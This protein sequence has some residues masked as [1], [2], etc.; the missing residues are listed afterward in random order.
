MKDTILSGKR[1]LYVIGYP[2]SGNTWLARLMAD[3]LDSPLVGGNNPIDRADTKQNYEGQFIIYKLHHSGKSKP[4]NITKESLILYI[5]RDFRD[6]LVSG[7]FHF[8]RNISDD[9]VIAENSLESKLHILYRFYFR[10]QILRMIRQWQGNEIDVL[11]RRARTLYNEFRFV[12]FRKKRT[13]QL[14]IGNWSEH[15]NYWTSFPNVNVI[16]Y[17]DLLT[18]PYNTLQKV[19]CKMG[20][21]HSKRNLVEIIERQSFKSRRKEFQKK[22]DQVNTK[23]LRKGVAGDWKRFL[24]EKMIQRIKKAHGPAM[25]RLGY[26][27]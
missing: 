17:E 27:I 23:F 4:C 5:V 10:H 18:D 21:N 3:L 16:K 12:V 15:V 8:Y 20:I 2:K 13:I 19:F 26:D 7:F 14:H 1:P 9:A 6:V 11:M 22:A 25:N 24:D